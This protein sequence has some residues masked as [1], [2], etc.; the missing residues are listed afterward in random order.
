M[1]FKETFHERATRVPLFFYASPAL[2][3]KYGLQFAPGEIKQNVS[4][5]DL[6]PTLAH[7]TSTPGVHWMDSWPLPV[8]GRSLVALLQGSTKPSISA[9]DPVYCEYTSEMVP[10]GWYMV[11]CRHLKLVYSAK[12]RPLLFDLEADPCEMRDVFQRDE[13]S[14]VASEMLKLAQERWPDIEGLTQRIFQSQ[15]ARRMIHQA[16][17]QGKR[18]LWDHDPARDTA[19]SYVRNTGVALQDQEYVCRAPYRGKRPRE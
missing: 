8:R 7:L 19:T 15:R 13:Y 4:L 1:W 12:H 10:G 11:K 5:A 3:E 16:M 6:M 17:L 18:T 9:S 2:S 14:T